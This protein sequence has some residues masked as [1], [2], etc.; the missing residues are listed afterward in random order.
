MDKIITGL[1][2]KV[3]KYVLPQTDL[4]FATYANLKT[5]K[6]EFYLK[7]STAVQTYN[8][9]CSS[10]SDLNYINVTILR[11]NKDTQMSTEVY[12]RK[13]LFIKELRSLREEVLALIE[14]FKYLKDGLESVVRFYA[15]FQYV[16]TSTRMESV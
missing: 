8:C 13:E 14:S 15:T 5:S 4:N 6:E 10:L 12:S 1:K 2:T 16:L 7:Y 3:A 11:L 9:V